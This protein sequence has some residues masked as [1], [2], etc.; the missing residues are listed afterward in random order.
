VR[1]VY[2][3]GFVQKLC[4]GGGGAMLVG[5]ASDPVDTN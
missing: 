1:A 2:G 5:E 4:F 3:C